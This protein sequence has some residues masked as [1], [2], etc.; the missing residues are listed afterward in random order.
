MCVC[1]RERERER[2]RKRNKQKNT[3]Q[4]KLVKNVYDRRGGEK[5]ACE[6]ADG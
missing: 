4:K 6:K 1:V 2:E 5:K 3:K